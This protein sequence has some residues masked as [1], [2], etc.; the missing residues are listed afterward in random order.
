LHGVFARADALPTTSKLAASAPLKVMA[1]VPSASSVMPKS[2]TL[3][4]VAV[5][6]VSKMALL[7]KAVVRATAVG[8]SLTSVTDKV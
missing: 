6:A 4:R 8:A 2:A 5:L 7:V 3:V 1:L